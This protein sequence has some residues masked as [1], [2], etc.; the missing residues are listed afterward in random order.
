[1]SSA[2]PTLSIVTTT[3]NSMQF[4]D[5]TVQSVL[6]LDIDR[7][8][9]VVDD[10]STDGTVR[11]ITDLAR[12]HDWI[13]LLHNTPRLNDPWKS[14]VKGLTHIRGKYVIALDSDDR[15]ASNAAVH[16][17]LA[18]LERQ[19]DLHIAIMKV[20]YMTEHGQIYKTKQIPFAQ[21]GKKMTGRR[22]FWTLF[23]SPTYPVKQGA[24]LIRRALFDLVGPIAD[25]DLVLEA[26]RYT[27]F[28]LVPRIGLHY[29][30]R[31]TSFTVNARLYRRE[32][33]W[34]KFADRYLP[35]ERFF[36]L[37]YAFSA[38]KLALGYCKIVY[39]VFS[40]NRI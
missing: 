32:E 5:E 8:W 12:K 20:A 38:Y 10:G 1:M 40:A 27:D 18:A 22:M 6:S 11:Y 25:I 24:I 33:F 16:E 37:K 39:S 14:C 23:L 13:R 9:I 17:A 21:Y 2:Q 36:G 4:L 29:R 26:T 31:S 3:F 7:E 34:I 19:P 35:N 28:A 15:L 30:N